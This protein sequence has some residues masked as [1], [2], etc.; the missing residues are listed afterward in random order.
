MI[1]N[2]T[3]HQSAS[4]LIG[5]QLISR[6][7]L[8]RIPTPRATHSWYPVPHVTVAD[9][10][11]RTLQ[12]EGYHIKSERWTLAKSDQRL[13]G[14]IDLAL[15]LA[16]WDTPGR[17][18]TVSLGVRSSFDKRLPLGIVAGSKVFVCSN[19]AFAGEISYK[20]KHTK[21]GLSVFNGQIE[22]AIKRLPQYQARE[23][24]RIE[25]WTNKELSFVE[26][27]AFVLA[28]IDSGIIGMRSIRG[29]LDELKQ[30]TFEEFGGKP[31]VWSTFNLITTALRDRASERIQE[32]STQSSRLISAMDEIIDVEFRSSMDEII[33]PL[34]LE[35]A[36]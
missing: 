31:T 5:D 33:T 4:K 27:D 20:R 35:Y 19:L 34:A 18:A 32:Y 15:P 1:I 36:S 11:I 13:F 6:S 8:A 21:N 17:G 10:V 16:R 14:V 28:L 23:S 22:S 9:S 12:D 24:Q 25:S 29:V 2:A 30:P 26:R 7:E 3:Q